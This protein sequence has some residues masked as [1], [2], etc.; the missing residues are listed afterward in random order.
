M[1]FR[2][3][4]ISF[5]LFSSAALFAQPA[6]AWASRYNGPADNADESHSIVVDNAGN[7]YVTGSAF[8]ASNNL[9]IVT[10]K[11]SPSGQQLWLQAYDG[12]GASNDEGYE[13]KLSDSGY[14]YVVG[15]TTTSA[16]MQDIITIKYSTAGVQQWAQLYNGS[17]N[18]YDAGAALEVDAAGNVYV[19]G[20]E[21]E[22]NY[23]Y[24][25]VTIKY[26]PGGQQL[27]AQTYNGPGNFNDEPYDIDIDAN[28]NVYVLVT[29]DTFYASQPNADIVVLK[30]NNSGTL[31]WRRVYDSSFHGYEYAKKMAIDRN[32][33]IIVAG[34][35]F[36]TGNGNDIYLLKWNSSGAFQWFQDYNSAPNKFEQPADLVVDSLNNV[37]VVG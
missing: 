28:N 4:L 35:G 17:F 29:S 14:V 13:I 18:N 8:N 31:Q 9:D 24:D 23:T 3:L 32:N 15:Y 37:I 36:V 30:Y 16:T 12:S 20:M 7:V 22:S 19:T 1:K 11:Y 2:F 10:I 25:A 6:Q 26:G 34:Y 27:W 21:T 5:F 33:D